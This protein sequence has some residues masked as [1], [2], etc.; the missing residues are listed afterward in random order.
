MHSEEELVRQAK[1]GSTEAFSLLVE[2]FQLPL[3]HFLL[4]R[5]AT[6]MDAEDRMQEAFLS[7]FRHIHTYNSRWRFS[8]WLFKIALRSQSL[9]AVKSDHLDVAP[10]KSE[11]GP[12]EQ[13]IR[14]DDHDNLWPIAK[15]I[16]NTE[17]FDALWLRYVEDL[18]I[19][20]VSKVLNRSNAWV[21]VVLFRA[22][23]DLANELRSENWVEA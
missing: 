7:A 12:L 18:S 13:C 5:S 4:A 17:Q 22:R 8:T 15:R 3:Y 11:L 2:R 19:K 21:K 20:E 16:L 1:Q 14:E 6:A 10:E 9:K 23:Q